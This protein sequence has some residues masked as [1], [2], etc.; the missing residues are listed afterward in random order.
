MR[1]EGPPLES[2]LRRLADCPAEFLLVQESAQPAIHAAAVVCD[3][4]RRWTPEQLPETHW[5]GL[6]VLQKADTGRQALAS[7]AAYLLA[8]DWFLKRSELAPKAKELFTAATLAKLAKLVKPERFV[9][10]A[11]RR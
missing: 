11:D 4:L 1:D 8:D 5:N 3:V 7:L 9:R 2:L 6:A 10:E